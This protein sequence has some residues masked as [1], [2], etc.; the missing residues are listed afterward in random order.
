VQARWNLRLEEGASCPSWAV[1]LFDGLSL[2][3]RQEP[4]W[5]IDGP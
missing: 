3:L 2:L 4:H 5:Q 1:D